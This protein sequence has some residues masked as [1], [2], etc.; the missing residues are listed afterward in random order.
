ML[1]REIGR[2]LTPA[3]L[4]GAAG[5]SAHF[6]WEEPVATVLAGAVGALGGGLLAPRA[7]EGRPAPVRPAPETPARAQSDRAL[8]E[9]LPLAILRID[10]ESAV[11]FANPIAAELFGRLPALPFHAAALRAPKLLAAIEEARAEGLAVTVEF[12]LMRGAELHLRAHLRPAAG[13]VV[14]LIEDIT[15]SRRS[16]QL[17]R[18]FVANASHELKTPLAS[19]SGIIET[20]QGHAR[21]DPEAAER[22]L[23]IMATQTERMRRLVEDML[24]LNRIE[25]NE[26]VPPRTPQSLAEIVEETVEALAPVAEAAGIDLQADLAG[27]EVAVLGSREE[28]SQVFQ[29]LVDNAIK[30]GRAGDSVAVRAL[31]AGPET[32]GRVGIAVVDT[33]PGIARTHLPRLTERFYRVSVPHSRAR[34]GTGLGLAIVKHVLSRHRGQLEIESEEGRGSRFTVWLPV[35]AAARRTG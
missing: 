32:G 9:H 4:A 1:L 18:D 8:L 2:S 28:L 29:N 21:D 19:I 31:P 33:G 10:R 5:A 35:A 24:S 34:G 3:I 25:Q 12:A 11:R 16:E 27:A 17:F 26:R 6:V 22:F 15:Q 13:D 14:V 20:L 23:G 7:P 30:Y